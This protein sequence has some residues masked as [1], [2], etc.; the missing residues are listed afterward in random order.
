MPRKKNIEKLSYFCRKL[1]E[2]RLAHNMTQPELADALGCTR[3]MVAYYEL[4]SP[5][6]TLDVIK[7]FADFYK[8]SAD[9]L[10]YEHEKDRKKAGQ[11]STLERQFEELQELPKSKQ[12]L[13]SDMLEGALKP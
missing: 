3:E 11:K 13:I 12:K 2:L 5:N 8:I 9:E 6:P 7:M 1:T 10:I 4:R